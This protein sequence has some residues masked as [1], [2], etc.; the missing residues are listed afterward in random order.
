MTPSVSIITA[1]KTAAAHLQETLDSIRAQ[2]YSLEVIVIDGASTDNTLAV[3]HANKDIITRYVSEPDKGI[4]D[5]FNKGVQ[6]ATGEY[7]NFQ[8]AGDTLYSPECIRMLFSD[9]DASY[10]LVCGRIVRVALDGT[11]P[12]W[13]AP[14][15]I[16]PFR[17]QSLLLRMALP[18]QGLFTHRSFFEKHGIFDPNV[19]FCMDYDLLLR[20][21]HQFPKTIL[22]EIIVS[23]WREGGIGTHREKEVFDEYHQ[24][25]K[26]NQVASD[27]TLWMINKYIRAKFCLKTILRS[28]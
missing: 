28:A 6:R 21:Y 22:K 16:K 14:R 4:S 17:V 18:H 9:L 19:Q 2:D 20:A 3:I 5:A 26:R 15:K 10:V 13:V 25:K 24:I 12:L 23:R 11:T 8:G 27:A 7:I 1:V